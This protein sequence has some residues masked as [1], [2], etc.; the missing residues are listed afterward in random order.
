MKDE[1]IVVFF[2]VFIYDL[3][4]V[5]IFVD[6]D[7]EP[8]SRFTMF[9]PNHRFHCGNNILLPYFRVSSHDSRMYA[10]ATQMIPL[11]EDMKHIIPQN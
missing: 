1:E 5:A 10:Y 6:P 11:F 9:I 2:I 8:L 3:E 4:Q 7:S